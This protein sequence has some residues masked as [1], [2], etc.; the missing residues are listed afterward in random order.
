MFS[1]RGR[2]WKGNINNVLGSV[3]RPNNNL[4]NNDRFSS[5]RI[6]KR[7]KDTSRV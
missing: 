7:R 3:I 1:K 6:Y 5:I 2:D 4:K